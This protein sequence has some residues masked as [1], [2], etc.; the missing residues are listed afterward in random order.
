VLDPSNPQAFNRYGYAYNNPIRFNDPTGHECGLPASS[1][2]IS[3]LHLNGTCPGPNV[4]EA[5]V[6]KL[7]VDLTTV[8]V[9]ITLLTEEERQLLDP[10][11]QSSGSSAVELP[12]HTEFPLPVIEKPLVTGGNESS[13]KPL[14]FLQSVKPYEVGSFNDLHG[15][16]DPYD[17]L[18]L[19]H[20]PQ[21]HP[22]GKII[23]GYQRATGPAIAL[24]SR[25]H[26]GIPNLR[27][28]YNGTLRDLVA[29]DLWNLRNYTNTPNNVLRDLLDFIDQTYPGEL[30]K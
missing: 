22:A 21:A 12:N 30:K 4:G 10:N 26:E 5:V 19:H 9:G 16:S 28:P 6:A 17:N 23:P 14:T 13:I 1:A 8:V 25:E 2:G 3:F 20:V 11:A 24:P 18:D 29:N 15:R 7:V 27:G